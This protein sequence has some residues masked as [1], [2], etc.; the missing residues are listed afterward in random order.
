MDAPRI[1]AVLP[2]A[3]RRLRVTFVNGI[4]K[5]YDCTPLTGLDRFRLL[6]EEAFF[7]AVRVDAGGYGISWND[8]GDLSEYE[9]WVRGTPAEDAPPVSP[10]TDETE[11]PASA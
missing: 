1:K 3:D 9:L 11:A 10:S 8:E 2:L 4:Q 7:K 6:R 5:D